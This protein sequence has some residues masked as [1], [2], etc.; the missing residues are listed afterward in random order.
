V[1]AYLTVRADAVARAYEKL[2]AALC[3][4]HDQLVGI[5]AALMSRDYGGEITMTTTPI[6]I[7]NFNLPSLTGHEYLATRKHIAS[8]HAVQDASSVWFAARNRL[9]ANPTA[10]LD[11]LIGPGLDEATK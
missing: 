7:P 3:R 8:E 1:L 11:Y 6:V 10:D 9:T 2:F 4:T 5:S